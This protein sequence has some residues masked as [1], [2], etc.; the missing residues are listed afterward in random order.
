MS[1]EVKRIIL[2]SCVRP[3]VE[4]GAEVWVPT[5]TQQRK[6]DAIQTNII[7][8]CMH[9]HTDKPHNKALLAEWGLKPMHMW[10]HERVLMYHARLQLMPDTRL[11]RRVFQASWIKHG[12]LVELPWQ[13]HVS[14]L[15]FKYGI[16]LSNVPENYL[17]CKTHIKA[18]VKELFCDD[19]VFKSPL[20]SSTMKRYIDWVSPQLV[21]SLSLKSPR[22]Y[23]CALS[24]TYGVEILMRIRLSCLPVHCRTARFR[25]QVDGDAEVED[26]GVH[27]HG[28]VCPSCKAAD[29]SLSHFLFECPVYQQHRVV[30]MDGIRSVP[31]CSVRLDACLAISDAAKRV[32]RFVSD[33]QWGS[34]SALKCVLPYIVAYL[35]KAWSARN[36]HKHGGGGTALHVS[37]SEMGRGADG[38]IAMAEG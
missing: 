17:K 24:P 28:L 29:E 26:R 27:T 12:N 36:S 7:K 9:I 21:S 38:R 16:D 31:E 22:P 4:F 1:V 25:L 18:S 14:G 8:L 13:K 23:L 15:L 5:I 3:I 30:M 20:D 32:C 34:P 2:L 33:N 37:A 19:L 6:L 11:P 35:A 10:L